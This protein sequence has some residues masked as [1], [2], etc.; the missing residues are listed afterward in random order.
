MADEEL[1]A[2]AEPAPEPTITEQ[3]QE[4]PEKELPADVGEAETPAEEEDSSAEAEIE[5]VTLERNG[6]SYQVP[7]ELEGEFLMQSDYTKKTQ[8]TAAKERE[9]EARATEIDQQAQITEAELDARASLRQMDERLSQYAQLSQADW[10]AYHDQDPMGTDKAWRDF[11]FLQ[12]KRYE[13]AQALETAQGERTQKAQQDF[14]KRVE[15]TSAFAKTIPGWSPEVEADV[16]KFALDKGVPQDFLRQNI[17]PKL[18]EIINLARLGAQA[19]QKQATAKPAPKLVE[20]LRM[21][22][23]KSSPAAS[24]SLAELADSD[25]DAFAKTFNQRMKA[26]R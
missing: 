11:Q 3:Q 20:P 19:M 18:Y 24:K 16:I 9:L 7:K 13:T 12:A 23:G 21:V 15:E 14:A 17:S 5:W 4:T 2:S 10:D 26:K 6:K 1:A 22:T 25:M 8:A